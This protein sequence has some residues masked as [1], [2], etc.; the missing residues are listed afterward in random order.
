MIYKYNF[1][2][3]FL[4][5][6]VLKNNYLASLIF[7]LEKRIYLSE[8]FNKIKDH[9]HIF[10]CGLARSGSTLLLKNIYNYFDFASFTY[11]DMPFVLS[12]NIYL[13]ICKK[14]INRKNIK[15]ERAHKDNVIISNKDPEAFE[16][17]FWKFISNNKYINADSLEIY[18][19]ST[20][21]LQEFVKLINLLLIK[22]NKNIY[23]SKNNNNILRINSII[24]VFPNSRILITF[25]NPIEHAQSLLNQ[26]L[27][28]TTLQKNDNFI[29]EY[30]S[31]IG[32][33]EF[34]IE[35]KFFKFDNEKNNYN[36][37]NLNYWLYEWIRIYNFIFKKYKSNKNVIFIDYN[38]Y[39]NDKNFYLKKI[40]NTNDNF[41]SKDIFLN[42]TKKAKDTSKI[43]NHLKLT[44]M[45][46]YKDILSYSLL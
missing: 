43:D 28:F 27:N 34:G 20:F 30:M 24:N 6:L 5:K 32:H 31:M 14:F 18:E 8:N 29:M 21:E 36:D 44:A 15:I 4:H 13:S 9:E 25:R 2:E 46:L 42:N 12:P 3:K 45:K 38:N 40:F 41:S 19:Y 22:N 37:K 11:N 39:C 1:L 33:Y 10:I 7:D 17:I 26:H 35:K 16:E 23:L